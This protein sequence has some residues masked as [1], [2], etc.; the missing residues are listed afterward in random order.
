MTR[1]RRSE[2]A[3]TSKH[4]YASDGR[5]LPDALLPMKPQPFP[6]EGT[7]L[8]RYLVSSTEAGLLLAGMELANG[9]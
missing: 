2:P 3:S 6:C 1:K 8:S 5:A 4:L 7:A 9:D